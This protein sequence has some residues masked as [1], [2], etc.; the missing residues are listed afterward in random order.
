MIVD[1]A[2]VVIALACAVLVGF[3]VPVLMQV[4]KTAAEAQSLI[5]NLNRDIPALLQEMRS[6]TEDV[7]V[8]SDQARDSVE[9]ASAL[10]HAV[11]EVGDSVQ[12][13]HNVV[14]GRSGTLF[15][16]LASLL[17]GVKAATT[18]VR[19]RVHH[20]KEGGESNGKR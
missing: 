4:K 5:S 8:I 7:S 6:V 20:N 13:V 15:A 12:Q 9:H 18:V 14:R 11:G 16:N 17:A 1:L 2:L 19:E 3:L 10:L